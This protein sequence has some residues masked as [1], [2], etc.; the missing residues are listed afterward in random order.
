MNLLDVARRVAERQPEPFVAPILAAPKSRVFTVQDGVPFEF[1]V[2]VGGAEV[3]WRTVKP[4]DRERARVG[5]RAQPWQR[6]MYLNALPSFYVI[7]LY[8]VGERAWLCTPYNAADA[9]QRGWKDGRPRPLHLVSE[10]MT[11]DVVV[12][13][14][15]AGV[16]LYDWHNMRLNVGPTVQFYRRNFHAG[17]PPTRMSMLTRDFRN[18]YEIAWDRAQRVAQA[19]R[20]RQLA[21]RR[22]TVRGRAEEHLGFMGA[23]LLAWDENDAGYRVRWSYGGREFSM[24]VRQDMQIASAGVCLD[25]TDQQHN[26]S[27]I[28]QV[29]AQRYDMQM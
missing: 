1:W 20:E 23:N 18:A 11:F 15:M 21:E 13:R 8:P 3:G 4:W 5:P 2:E 26:L 19:E 9:A 7:A 28:V 27:S 17:V 24:D 14:S 29:M 25:G 6:V 12:A 22:V 16:L 10:L